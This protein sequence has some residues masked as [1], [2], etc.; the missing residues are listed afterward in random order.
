VHAPRQTGK[1]AS[2]AALARDINADGRQTALLFSCERARI[3]TDDVGAAG[4][5]ILYAITQ[6]A[7]FEK[8]P[9]DCMPP[10]ACRRIHGQ[11]PHRTL[12]CPPDC[13]PGQ[14]LALVGWR[15]FSTR[16]TR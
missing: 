8:L 2:L 9:A 12:C 3:Y 5:A 1:T 4:R 14:R 7:R 11:M 10:T 6:A 15:Y 16:L 13:K